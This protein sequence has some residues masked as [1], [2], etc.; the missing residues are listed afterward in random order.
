MFV[1]IWLPQVHHSWLLSDQFFCLIICS[2][3]LN[4]SFNKRRTFSFILQEQ[5]Y[6]VLLSILYCAL[7]G[8]VPKPIILFVALC[9]FSNTYSSNCANEHA[10][11]VRT[12]FQTIRCFRNVKSSSV[13]R[14]KVGAAGDGRVTDVRDTSPS[15]HTTHPLYTRTC[16]SDFDLWRRSRN[17]DESQLHTALCGGGGWW[18]SRLGHPDTDWAFIYTRTQHSA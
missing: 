17:R 2:I 3:Y 18:L 15:H 4:N 8:D 9:A 12:Y 14:W 13:F 11:T 1:I 5:L 7:E 10:W 6:T 16:E